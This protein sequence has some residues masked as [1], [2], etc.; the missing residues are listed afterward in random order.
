MHIYL[1]YTI[2]Y[3]EEVMLPLKFSSFHARS[4]ILS[5][6]KGRGVI[7]TQKVFSDSKNKIIIITK[8]SVFN[9]GT[10]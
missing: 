7:Q 2:Y 4:Q 5:V 1:S 10:G 3:F 9:A 6:E 8:I